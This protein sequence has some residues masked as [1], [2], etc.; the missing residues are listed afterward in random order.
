[1]TEE[2]RARLDA[3]RLLFERHG[4]PIDLLAV[5]MGRST[6]LLERRAEEESWAPI[7]VEQP[8]NLRTRLAAAIER[9][10]G[11]LEEMSCQMIEG[12][13]AI[14]RA[15]LDTLVTMMRAL[16]K[17]AEF[18]PQDDADS[19]R[20]IADDEELA[21]ILERVNGRIVELARAL[22]AQLAETKLHAGASA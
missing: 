14:D 18:V 13:V 15:E 20:Q 2:M 22:A 11:K 8:Q 1:M 12:T 16:E 10:A 7:T 9:L 3:A 6:A 5:A 21:A 4:A 19:E 17:I